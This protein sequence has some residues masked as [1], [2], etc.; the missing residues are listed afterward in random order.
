M[1]TAPLVFNQR[2][3]DKIHVIHNGDPGAGFS[4]LIT[5]ALNGVRRAE[6]FNWLPVVDFTRNDTPHFYDPEYGNN[7]WEYYFEPVADLGSTKLRQWLESGKVNSEQIHR[8]TDAEVVEWHVIDPDRITTFWGP[9]DVDDRQTWM[10]EK[11]QLGREY[12]GKYVRLKPHIGNK[13]ERL[14]ARLFHA[15]VMF[16]V[17]IRGTDFSYAKPTAIDEYFVAIETRIEQQGLADFGIFL[18]TDQLQFVTAFNQRFP[19]RVVTCDAARSSND[20]APFKL[21]DVSAY[22]KGEDVLLDILLLSR[23]DYLFKSVSA[24][25]EY[26]LWFNP[27]LECTDFALTSEYLPDKSIFWTGVYL[28]LDVDNKG[29]VRIALLTWTRIAGQVIENYWHR[30]LRLLR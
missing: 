5:Y 7:V 18:A 19:N 27:R 13:L 12:V 9:T 1:S 15:P 26:A 8:Y 21:K 3:Y 14:H 16:G 10:A 17:H 23:C 6:S 25:G 4:A 29:P 24:V 22:K 2:H 30:L 28:K 20:V 11:R